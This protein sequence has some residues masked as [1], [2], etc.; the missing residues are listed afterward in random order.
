[1][2]KACSPPK[3]PVRSYKRSKPGQGARKKAAAKVGGYTCSD[4]HGHTCGTR[5]A[6]MTAAVAHRKQLDRTAR[7]QGKSTRYDVEKRA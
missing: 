4:G 6:T 3:N 5:H 1:M 7:R 2:P